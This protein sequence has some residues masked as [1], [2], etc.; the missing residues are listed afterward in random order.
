M[1]NEDEQ[2]KNDYFWDLFLNQSSADG[3]TLW[4]CGQFPLMRYHMF[5]WRALKAGAA[6]L[7]VCAAPS[8]A[9]CTA[10][11]AGSSTMCF[12]HIAGTRLLPV[13][14]HSRKN[15]CHRLGNCRSHRVHQSQRKG[16]VFSISSFPD[17]SVFMSV[18]QPLWLD[19]Q[20]WRAARGSRKKLSS[21]SDQKHL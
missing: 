19:K 1:S 20:C 16:S 13:H 21:Q 5:T 11:A 8:A 6:P 18:F 17:T 9:V 2:H 3:E 15:S 14:R 7:W 4:A 10:A 12:H